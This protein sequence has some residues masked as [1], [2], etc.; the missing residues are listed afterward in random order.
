MVLASD[1]MD[2]GFVTECCAIAEDILECAGRRFADSST[3]NTFT[4]S[5]V[6][7]PSEHGLPPRSVDLVGSFLLHQ[8][9]Y[10]LLLFWYD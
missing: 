9:S 5:M 6:N 10:R 1:G 3:V 7:H 8:F 2:E 4:N